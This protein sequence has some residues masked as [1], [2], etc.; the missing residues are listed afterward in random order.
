MF[1]YYPSLETALRAVY[2]HF[3]WQT[4][5]FE[6]AERQ[7]KGYK[8][9]LNAMKKAEEMLNIKQVRLVRSNLTAY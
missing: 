4:S 6:E 3:P 1:D 2:P 7:R 9:V 5:K 8:D